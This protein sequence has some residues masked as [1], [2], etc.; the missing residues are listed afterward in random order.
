MS[1]RDAFRAEQQTRRQFGKAKQH[2][3]RLER[4]VRK[5]VAEEIALAIEGSDWEIH[6]AVGST[7]MHPKTALESAAR[8]ARE[9]GSRDPE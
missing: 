4:A 1:D 9:I 8:I 3:K 6:T 2:E 7:H 5:A